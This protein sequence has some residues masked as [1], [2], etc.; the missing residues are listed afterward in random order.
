MFERATTRRE[1]FAQDAPVRCPQCGL[2]L[3]AAT[4]Q[5][6]HALVFASCCPRCDG[7]LAGSAASGANAA[8]RP[9]SQPA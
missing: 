2:T 4:I 3:H 5:H 1:A 8:G 9:S 6:E 7:R